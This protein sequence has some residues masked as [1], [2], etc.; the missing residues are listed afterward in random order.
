MIGRRCKHG[1]VFSLPVL[2]ARGLDLL[3]AGF[4]LASFLCPVF[5]VYPETVGV[6]ND[7]GPPVPIPNTEVKL[8]S[9]DDTCLATGRENRSTPTQ[10]RSKERLC[11]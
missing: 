8:I 4:V 1:N 3:Y 10:S 2:I 5:R 11:F 9:A 6:F 7:E